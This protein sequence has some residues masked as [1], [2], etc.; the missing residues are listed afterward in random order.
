MNSLEKEKNK[1]GKIEKWESLSARIRDALFHK[2]NVFITNHWNLIHHTNFSCPTIFCF[3][4]ICI[5]CGLF[6]PY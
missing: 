4:C 2:A 3:L 5:L 6:F 1:V